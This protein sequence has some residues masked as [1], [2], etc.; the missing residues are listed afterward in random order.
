MVWSTPVKK[1]YQLR[2]PLSIA[3][4]KS[5][6]THY[7][8][9]IYLLEGMRGSISAKGQF[10]IIFY[11]W[12][13]MDHN[14]M[15]KVYQ[16]RLPLLIALYKSYQT[17]YCMM[18]YLLEGTRGSIS[19]KGQFLI[20]FYFWCSMDHNSIDKTVREVIFFSICR[21]FYFL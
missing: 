10:F 21:D 14:F 11:F 12:C 20:F 7:N 15:K 19:A 6:Q 17:H 9:T 16:P 3:L 2:L 5:Y 8:M 1:V 4:L 13:L 18:I